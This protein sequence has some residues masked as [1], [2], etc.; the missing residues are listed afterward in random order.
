[1]IR[2]FGMS[3]LF[4]CGCH[5][6]LGQNTA[7][8]G[9][10]E[11][12][13]A[14]IRP[15]TAVPSQCTGGPGSSDPG[16]LTCHNFSLSY[17][18]MM[19]YDLRAYQFSAP[20]WMKT[21]Q[22]DLTASVRAGTSVPEFR[23]MQQRL[24]AERFKLE[25]HFEEKE[26]DGYEL[27]VAKSSPNLKL[28]PEDEAAPVEPLWSPPFVGP[29]AR[30]KAQFNSRKHG[31]AALVRFVADRLGRPVTDA[32]GLKGGY[33]FV[34]RYTDD[35]AGDGPATDDDSGAG[36]EA[37]LK[38]QLGLALVKKKVQVDILV[39]DHAEKTPADN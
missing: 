14:S 36:I 22:F 34:L 32:T 29:P 7:Q 39:V 9:R 8:Q 15:A 38:E 21:T 2:A 10:P 16:L 30:A 11:F 19:A 13:A 5:M 33:D 4:I 3:A 20:D 18:G 23:L 6:T 37:A 17:L 28:V 24:L 25:V 35:P 1:M 27:V 26:I 12:E 31:M